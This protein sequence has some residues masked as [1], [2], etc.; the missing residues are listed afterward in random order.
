MYFREYE[1][2]EFEFPAIVSCR[3][4]KD[5]LSFDAESVFQSW[6]IFN[7]EDIRI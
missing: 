2:V 3:R 7:V 1:I 4:M 5:I 6:E